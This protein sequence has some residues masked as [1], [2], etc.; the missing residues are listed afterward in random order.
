MTV[1]IKTAG[2]CSE[3]AF[4]SKLICFGLLTILENIIASISLFFLGDNCPPN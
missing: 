1:H 4:Y 3:M 2:S